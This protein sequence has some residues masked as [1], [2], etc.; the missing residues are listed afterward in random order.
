MISKGIVRP[1]QALQLEISCL[2][3]LLNVPPPHPAKKNKQ[4]SKN[5]LKVQKFLRLKSLHTHIPS[6]LPEEIKLEYLFPSPEQLAVGDNC[7]HHILPHARRC[8]QRMEVLEQ[9]FL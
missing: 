8:N 5:R 6:T 3:Q 1:H 7:G 4:R 2:F 9:F